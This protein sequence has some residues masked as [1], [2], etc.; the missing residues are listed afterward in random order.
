MGV[1]GGGVDVAMAQQIGH[2]LERGSVLDQVA[3][4]SMTQQM[5]S[6][7]RHLDGASLQRAPDHLADRLGVCCF[8]KDVGRG[9]V[10]R[11]SVRGE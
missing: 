3:G 10:R 7:S 4:Q 8:G 11:G 5:R 1:N 9:R 6:G 2:F